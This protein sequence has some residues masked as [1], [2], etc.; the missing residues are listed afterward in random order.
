MLYNINMDDIQQTLEQIRQTD[1]FF[2]K[3]KLIAYLQ[4]EKKVHTKT[5][6]EQLEMKEAYVCH[7]NRLNKLPDLVIDGYYSKLI[8]VSHLFIIARLKDP[9]QM[10]EVYEKV[11]GSGL[12]V[13]KT[14]EL[15]REHLY[16]VKSEGEHLNKDDTN[17]TRTQLK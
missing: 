7:I 15:V 17:Y 16:D 2:Q 11:L 9:G 14:E 3:A 6:S 10:L 5:L 8:S 1:D 4:K 13:L 12:T